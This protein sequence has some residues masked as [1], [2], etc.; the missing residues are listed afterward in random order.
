MRALPI[1]RAEYE[2]AFI[3]QATCAPAVADGFV[4]PSAGAE[5]SPTCERRVNPRTV[6]SPETPTDRGSSVESVKTWDPQAAPRR[7]ERT[8]F[9]ARVVSA[10]GPTSAG[11]PP[12]TKA[13]ARNGR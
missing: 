7:L 13:P 10:C 12:F 3:Q 8:D 5:A 2:G 11:C 9:N 1:P 6:W 4:A